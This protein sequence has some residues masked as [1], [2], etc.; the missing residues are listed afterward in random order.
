[1]KILIWKLQNNY[2]CFTFTTL[3]ALFGYVFLHEFKIV[4][5]L[6]ACLFLILIIN[7]P[8]YLIVVVS[9]ILVFYLFYLIT[10]QSHHKLNQAVNFKTQIVKKYN[11][12]FIVKT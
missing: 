7:K 9:L 4:Y 2:F 3:S 8:Y 10:D 11:Q 5:L 6:F 12:C 1:M